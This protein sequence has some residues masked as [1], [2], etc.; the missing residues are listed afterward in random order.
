MRLPSPA[1]RKAIR[2]GAGVQV[3]EL[4][5][6]VG[7]TDRTVRHWEAGTR[8]PSGDNLVRYVEALDACRGRK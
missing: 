4:A 3:P 2:E 8:R 7:V 1:V 5:D 6:H